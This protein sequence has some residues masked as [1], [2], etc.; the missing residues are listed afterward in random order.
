[1]ACTACKSHGEI[2][3]EELQRMK[4]CGACMAIGYLHEDVVHIPSPNPTTNPDDISSFLGVANG[5]T[6]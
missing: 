4:P 1:V 6:E 5:P 3:D 2:W